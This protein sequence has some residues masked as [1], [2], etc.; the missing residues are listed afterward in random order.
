MSM[1]VRQKLRAFRSLVGGNLTRRSAKSICFCFS[2]GFRLFSSL[3]FMHILIAHLFATFS[4]W[5]LR[6][7]TILFQICPLRETK[8]CGAVCFSGVM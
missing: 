1:A 7:V 6:Q 2:G 3:F 5:G 8:S 4:E